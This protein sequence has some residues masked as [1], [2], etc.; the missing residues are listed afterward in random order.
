MN[1]RNLTI[2]IILFASGLSING[3]NSDTLKDDRLSV[4]F[5]ATVVYQFKP[6][7][8]V[9][10]SGVNS[11]QP[12]QENKTSLTST[13]FLGIRLWKGAS[14][15]VNP[16]IAGG[17]GLSSTLGIAAAPNGETY[18][19]GDPAPQVYLARLFYRQIFPL[20]AGKRY[21]ESDLNRLGEHLPDQ[22]IA[23]TIGKGG[24]SDYFDANQYSHDPR[25]Q[26]MS[27]ALMSNGAWDY[28]ANT[29]GY[30]PSIIIEF[31]TPRHELKYGISLVPLSANGMDMNW[32]IL[33]ANS[34][35]LE[36]TY[37]Y[38]LNKRS[39]AIRL[40]GFFTTAN[41]GNYKQSM[42]LDPQSPVIEH[43][44]EYGHSKYGFGI[45]AEQE[46]NDFSGCFFR[47]GWNDG[48]NETWAFTEIDHT[49]SAGITITGAKWKRNNDNIG[50][51][52]VASGISE[53]H[54]KYLQSGGLGF[55]LGDGNLDYGGEY[56][57]ELYYSAE[58]VK[59]YIYLS[60][61]YQLLINPAYN[62]DRKGFVNIFSVRLHAKI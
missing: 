60:G 40:L 26:F 12:Q 53:P 35:T 1:L 32:Q 44:R 52:F 27:W 3:Q 6:A 59:R 43:T 23:F 31:V 17:Y 56:L 9:K 21:Q 50:L 48:N 41:M 33:L 28:P 39:G 49:I 7:F 54:R 13:L 38:K 37:R 47:A 58:L 22:Y 46:I 51:A 34:N 4:H 5:Q 29:R 11:L 55:M 20:S 62:T 61:A 25:T 14:F 36:Y 42:A 8:S 2:I 45:N 30:T 15:F 16:E 18:R 10:Y 19:I 24:I 57:T